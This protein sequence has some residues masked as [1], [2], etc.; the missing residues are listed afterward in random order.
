MRKA[1]IREAPYSV[2]Q[3]LRRISA[4]TI[5]TRALS[6]MVRLKNINLISND[7]VRLM[8]MI[9]SILQHVSCMVP[10][11]TVLRGIDGCLSVLIQNPGI[12]IKDKSSIRTLLTMISLIYSDASALQNHPGFLLHEEKPW[13]GIENAMQVIY[14]FEPLFGIK[15]T[16]NLESLLIESMERNHSW[17][18][19]RNAIY[20]S[21]CQFDHLSQ[22]WAESMSYHLA[23][24][25]WWSSTH[26]VVDAPSYPRPVL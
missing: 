15:K 23:D 8:G 1:I 18:D 11:T 6:R 24:I 10:S 14:F 4:P 21:I 2:S 22:K 13:I 26:R 17:V 20:S 19:R 12:R 16:K 5:E 9:R 25:Y 7:R 3:Y